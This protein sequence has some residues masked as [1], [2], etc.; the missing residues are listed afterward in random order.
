MNLT[1]SNK[2]GLGFFAKEEIDVGTV[3]LVSKPLVMIMG[4]EED[5][6]ES[7]SQEDEDF[8]MEE[9]E[10]ADDDDGILKGS[11]RNGILVLRLL[12]LIKQDAK[13]WHDHLSNLYPR[14]QDL[15]DLPIWMSSD[16]D[17]GIQIEKA[18]SE[19][20][21]DEIPP[22]EQSPQQPQ[23]DEGEEEDVNDH[24]VPDLL[25]EIQ[26]R[27]PLI[28]RYNCL[29]VETFPELFSHPN[30]H[31]GGHITLSS[32][33]LYT[34][35]SY[36]NHDSKPNVSRWAIGDVMFFVTNQRVNP[37]EELCISYIEAEVLC[38][39]VTRRTRLL[40]MDFV[41]DVDVNE[42]E[43]VDIVIEGDEEDDDE[44]TDDYGSGAPVIN[45]EVQ[46]E[47]MAMAPLERLVEIQD[48]LKQAIQYETTRAQ[49]PCLPK[50]GQEDDTLVEEDTIAWF[51]CDQHQLRVLLALTYDS[52]GQLSKAFP[53]WTQCVSF[54]ST[55]LPPLDENSIV[56]QVQAALCALAMDRFEDAKRYAVEALD[57]HSKVFGC[58]V[59][60]FRKRYGR[61]VQ[62]QLRPKGNGT[63]DLDKLWP[64]H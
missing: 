35:P 19:L 60:L 18:L 2:G 28:V 56:M 38:E 41:D 59:E 16:V 31:Q 21:L 12:Q 37:G 30:P 26:L 4:W 62:L 9:G 1:S 61:E 8:K 24:N 22:I 17:I 39:D 14:N 63:A 50:E 46:E 42:G 48:L 54:T 47:I 51:K 33:A 20:V 15:E 58:G 34:H 27:L 52:M 23:N 57:I 32:T 43:E 45:A 49:S 25:S 64:L 7:E 11:K 55:H 10:E 44:D 5:D 6:F 40:D 29:S 3:L 53:Q 13:V 36:F